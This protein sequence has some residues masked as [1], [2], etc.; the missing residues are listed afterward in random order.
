MN[1]PHWL[2]ALTIPFSRSDRARTCTAGVDAGCAEGLLRTSRRVSFSCRRALG[3]RSDGSVTVAG[4]GQT[5]N[6]SWA[7]N[8]IRVVTRD[9]ASATDRSGT[10]A[11]PG[12]C[13][14]ERSGSLREQVSQCS[15]PGAA[16]GSSLSSACRSVLEVQRAF[17]PLLFANQG[18]G[19]RAPPADVL[20]LP[21]VTTMRWPHDAL[22]LL[23]GRD[24]PVTR[25]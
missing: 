24:R 5:V 7:P 6:A 20:D 19:G 14:L 15:A 16:C 11:V 10:P 12:G 1:C 2:L 25:Q 17:R 23:H 21:H 22:L 13:P 18:F 8:S 3:G 4:A 9:P